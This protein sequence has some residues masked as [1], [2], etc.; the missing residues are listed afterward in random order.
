MYTLKK[1]TFSNRPPERIW[2]MDF[3]MAGFS[4]THRIL[5]VTFINSEVVWEKEGE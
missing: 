4:A 3:D 5:M 2:A 1:H